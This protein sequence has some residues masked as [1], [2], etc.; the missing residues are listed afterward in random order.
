MPVFAQG[1]EKHRA[2][3]DVAVFTPLSAMNVN[4]HSLA[5]HIGDFQ[6][7]QFGASHTGG[8][9]DHEQETVK[10]SECRVDESRDLFL[11]ENHRQ[12]EHSLRIGGL[13]RIPSLL[14]GLNVEEA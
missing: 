10:R 4:D 8:I 13:G 11:A 12:V 6:T 14:E 2:K 3:H 9:E 5:V 7:G 1:C